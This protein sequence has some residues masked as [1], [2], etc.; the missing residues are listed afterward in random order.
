MTGVQ[1]C[2][3]PIYSGPNKELNSYTLKGIINELIENNIIE[4]K[5]VYVLS[6]KFIDLRILKLEKKIDSINLLISNFKIT[7]GVYMPETQTNAV[8]ANINDI[9]QKIFKNSLQSEL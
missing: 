5:S 9:D 6:S 3:L 2:A 7:N 1:T 4:K 8:L